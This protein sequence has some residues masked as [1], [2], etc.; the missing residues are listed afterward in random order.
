MT[1]PDYDYEFQTGGSLA[2]DNPSYVERDADE[3]LYQAIKAR[4]FAYVFNCRQ[5]GKSSL[6]VRTEDRLKSEGYCCAA[7]D[8]SVFGVEEVSAAQ[9][10]RTLIGE[11]NRRLGD[12]LPPQ[13]L[14]Q[15]REQQREVAPVYR[16]ERFIE[17]VVLT[18]I[19]T[20]PI[21]IFVDEIDT[22]LSLTF[23]AN[24]FFAWIRSCYNRRA[25]EPNYRR[26]TFVLLGVTTPSQLIR[27]TDRTPFNIGQAIALGGLELNQ[28]QPLV[29]GLVGWVAESERVLTEIF[30]W[31]GGQPYLTQKLCALVQE[32][33]M[34][35]EELPLIAAGEAAEAIARLVN[36]HLIENWESGD[37]QAH[38]KTIRDRILRREQLSSRML[39]VYEQ[40]LAEE[41][42]PVDNSDTQMEL[43][44]TGLVVARHGNLEV[45]NPIYRHIFDETWVRQTLENLRPYAESFREWVASDY[46]DEGH[47]LQGQAL[48]KAQIWAKGKSLS[49]LDDRYLRESQELENREV[50]QKLEQTETLSQKIEER[51]QTLENLNQE[52]EVQIHKQNRKIRVRSLFATAMLIASVAGGATAL[53]I[54]SRLGSARGELGELETT[55]KTREEAL[56]QSQ[57]EVDDASEELEKSNQRL[58]QNEERLDVLEVEAQE[59]TEEAKVANQSASAAQRERQRAEQQREKAAKDAEEAIAEKESAINEREIATE[60]AVLARDVTFLE[61]LGMS[62]L[63]KFDIQE[64]EALW[65]A[66]RFSAQANEIYIRKGQNFLAH[67]PI[68]ALQMNLTRIREVCL[69]G[70]RGGIVNIA[71]NPDGSRLASSG[72]DGTIRIWDSFGKQLLAIEAHDDVVY[73]SVFSPDGEMIASI[74]PDNT[75]KLWDLEGNQLARMEG[76]HGGIEQIIFN[77]NGHIIATSGKTDGTVRLWDLQGNERA[78]L[79]SH[80][81]PVEKIEFNADG[82]RLLTVGDIDGVATLW[83]LEGN[84]LRRIE[85]TADAVFN[86][87]GSKFAVIGSPT[88]IF[89]RDGFQINQL[90]VDKE[91]EFITQLVFS[92]NGLTLATSTNHGQI[93]VW[94]LSGN[95]LMEMS[96]SKLGGNQAIKFSPDGSLLFHSGLDGIAY[97]RSL[98]D[99]SSVTMQNHEGRIMD[100]DFN[101]DGSRLVTVD[102]AR[103]IRAWDLDGNPLAEFKGHLDDIYDV[104]FSPDDS[105]IL[106]S[107]NDGTARLWKLKAD[108][109]PLIESD[110]KIDPNQY[111]FHEEFHEVKFSSDGSKIITIDREFSQFSPDGPKLITNGG[112]VMI[113]NL[114]GNKVAKVSLE[115]EMAYRILFNP[116]SSVFATYSS[117]GKI[118]LW[119]LRGSK[120]AT[121]DAFNV[122]HELETS[123]FFDSFSFSPDGSFLLTFHREDGDIR[124]WSLEGEEITK[125]S[126]D[127]EIDQAGVVFTDDSLMLIVPTHGNIKVFDLQGNELM[128]FEGDKRPISSIYLSPDGQNFATTQ[129]VYTPVELETIVKIWDFKGNQ[130]SLPVN[131][132]NNYRFSEVIFSP[133]GSR[134]LA[135][136]E[137]AM[138][139]DFSEN[140]SKILDGYRENITSAA[141]S[142]DG[143]KI[144]TG[145]VE[146]SVRL[147][148]LGGEELAVM[149]G[150]QSG[151]S[152]ITFHPS[153]SSLA[154]KS[155]ED[156]TTRIWTTEGGQIG[157]YEGRVALNSNWSNIA[158][159]EKSF[160]RDST[161][162][163]ILPVYTLKDLGNLLLDSCKVLSA[164]KNND[165]YRANCNSINSPS[166]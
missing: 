113:W 148:S 66:F 13:E 37:E 159:T 133:D 34:E 47:L 86:S 36:H 107:S 102:E 8:L 82:S 64:T 15:W 77:P 163:R 21:V 108:F 6:R 31:T 165:E 1:L 19:S 54:Y 141:F 135:I 20:Q 43:R 137:K 62:A 41:G 71:F 72:K 124:L 27:N 95:Q 87:D 156:G 166:D 154:T 122:N 53:D 88:R 114:T 55:L 110:Q 152:E 104:E 116:E 160:L 98:E 109:F 127:Q 52:A 42:I 92:P 94:D 89:D 97:L 157:H 11:L 14:D 38:F 79:L 118:H 76:H 155:R 146:G 44:L 25:D 106:S 29:D 93:Q 39:S 149:E 111:Q 28:A 51:R 100:V 96:G 40:V 84:R 147:W 145:G 32:R 59:A 60:E 123:S 33:A 4:K 67:N 24:D 144:A 16:L 120:I 132:E 74:S 75:A 162:I 73:R 129:E 3:A 90:D 56:K 99:E 10:Y 46:E 48:A 130:I 61:R 164:Y 139:W 150:H 161:V 119:N 83:D 105:Y 2:A 69:T 126:L 49:A 70:H 140:E 78:T 80:R 143:S 17:E 158:I 5:M 103:T 35:A 63:E 22:V 30:K 45:F 121:I 117:E 9:W 128:S 57:R 131:E 142:P 23:P 12:V 153:S 138:V 58:M 7:I 18:N 81:G 85:A 112:E 125:I 50:R 101:L 91:S 68:L 115:G 26:L 151:I 65:D 136:G 134:I